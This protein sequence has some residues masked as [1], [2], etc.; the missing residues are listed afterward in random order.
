MKSTL[1]TLRND[2][3]TTISIE[4]GKYGARRDLGTAMCCEYR[5]K[6]LQALLVCVGCMELSK[7]DWI[8]MLT[9]YTVPH[10][11]LGIYLV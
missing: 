5:R 10:I 9:M 7:I 8:M 3:A 11:L 1:C 4:K 6:S 2:R